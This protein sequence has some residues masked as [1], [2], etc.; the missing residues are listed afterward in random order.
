[1][2]LEKMEECFGDVAQRKGYITWPQLLEALEIQIEEITK[3]GEV[4]FI[5]EILC[6]L[7]FTTKL[8][9]RDVLETMGYRNKKKHV[10][11]HLHKKEIS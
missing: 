2:K 7:N 3:K 11:H 8:E 4:R 9:V 10:L 5:G 6:D 1:L